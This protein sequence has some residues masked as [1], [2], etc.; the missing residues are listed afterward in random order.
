MIGFFGI[1]ADRHFTRGDRIGTQCREGTVDK[2]SG[3]GLTEILARTKGYRSIDV[4]GGS[5][6]PGTLGPVEGQFF[7]IHGEKILAKKLT[8]VFKKVTEVTDYRIVAPNSLLGLG[9]IGNINN[10]NGDKDKTDC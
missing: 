7:A 8:Q 9:N 1:R 3:A 5:I 2:Y 10:N 4:F 6:D